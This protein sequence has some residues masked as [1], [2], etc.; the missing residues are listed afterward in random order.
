MICLNFQF[1][2]DWGRGVLQTNST[3]STK[4]CSSFHFQEGV[5]QTNSNSKCQDLPKFSLGEYSRPIQT[6]SAKLCP[7]FQFQEGGNT[8]DQLKLKSAKICP[9]F[10][11]GGWGVLQTNSTQSAKICP[12][13]HWGSAPD[14]L[15][16]KVPSSVQIVMGGY[17]RPTETHSA[18][19]CPNFHFQGVGVLQTNIPE[20]LEWGHSRNFEPKILPTGMCIASHVVSHILMTNER[21]NCA[22][23][24]HSMFCIV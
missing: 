10:H 24:P 9:N 15:R 3:Q 1:Q 23:K 5:L 16:L 13:F 4:I 17:S 11:W 22:C 7:N 6:Q 20:I 14:Q 8:P 18:K 2:G 19:I 21:G 12:N